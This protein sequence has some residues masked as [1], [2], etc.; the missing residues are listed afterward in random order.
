MA[1]LETFRA[2]TRA[3]LEAN[4][5]EEMRKPMK[6]AGD[7]QWGGRN[8]EFSSDEQRIW[9]ERMS[10]KGWTVPTWPEDCGGAALSNAEAKVLKQE[11]R[12]LN[13]RTPLMSFG[14]MMLGP[15]V[16]EYG[17]E[18]QKREFLPP[19]ARGEI[20]WCQG[21][22]E[23][24]AGSDLASLQCRA[25]RDGDEYVVNGQ[26]FWTSEAHLSDWIFC[27][28]RSNPKASK[29]DGISFLLIDMDDPGVEATPIEL[30][31][32][33][34]MFCQTFFDDVRVPVSNRIGDEDAG[35]TIA[36]KLLQHEREM[37]SD[38]AGGGSPT[39]ARKRGTLAD[40]A[41]KS[42]GAAEGPLPDA[43]LRDRIARVELDQLCYNATLRRSADGAKAGRGVGPETSM[44]KLYLSELNKRKSDLR[45][46]VRGVN[47]LGWS[48]DSFARDD[49]AATREW[50]NSKAESIAGGTS[51][52]QRNIIA[53]RV[54]GLPD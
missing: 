50:L 16:L 29:H 44:F 18:A 51:E 26:K 45:V 28:V 4:C 22:S 21:Y 5:P 37:L 46:R 27:L 40:D 52:I 23:P 8:R 34:S 43:D 39:G 53:K 1:D 12:A 36:K 24:G 49:L 33:A 38:P 30:I 48:G 10:E 9:L 25:A 47:G 42:L 2:D 32:G 19:I 54:L 17:T 15:V 11:M 3:W 13:C 20:R 7:V 14:I 35:W 6:A 31:S 41:R